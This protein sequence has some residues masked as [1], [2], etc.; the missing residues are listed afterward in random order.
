MSLIWASSMEPHWMVLQLVDEAANPAYMADSMSNNAPP[1][2]FLERVNELWTQIKTTI[3]M[4]YLDSKMSSLYD[5]VFV[6]AAKKKGIAMPSY[7]EA[8]YN[9]SFVLSN[10][11]VSLGEPVRLPQNFIP[12]G[13]YHLDLKTKPLPQDLQKIMD[14]AKDGVIYFSMGS[15]LKSKHMPA[16]MK[17]EF[18]EVFGQLKQTVIW[19]FEEALPDVPKNVHMLK[20]APQQSILAH[21]NCVLFITHGGL[22]S[23]T[24][25]VHFGV[26]IIGIPVFG[27]Q[28]INVERAVNKGIAVKVDLSYDTPKE[29]K[30]AIQ[31]VLSNPSSRDD[32]TKITWLL[33]YRRHITDNLAILSPHSYL[34]RSCRQPFM[35]RL[36]SHGEATHP[37]LTFL[38]VS[39]HL[40]HDLFNDSRIQFS[41]DAEEAYKSLSGNSEVP[42]AGVPRPAGAPGQAAGALGGARG[43]DAR[44][45]APALARAHDALV[46]EDVP[47]PSDTCRHCII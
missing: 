28:F 40:I 12:V 29:L 25:T 38:R 9:A 32:D 26:P 37:C 31:E 15:N 44:R 19:K 1:F 13:G 35:N 41:N 21:P 22:L 18:L 42:L 45:A 4:K 23:S 14:N 43:Q 39:N 46:P 8:V 24:E 2:T 34:F 20:W 10:S 36:N 27:D 3:I 30:L 17:R 6:A 7:K 5:E 11:H 16:V 33:A 47:R